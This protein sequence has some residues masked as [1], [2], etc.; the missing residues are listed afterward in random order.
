VE[1]GSGAPP[2]SE[3][4]S[5]D[6]ASGPIACGAGADAGAGLDGDLPAG[7]IDVAADCFM[8]SPHRTGTNGKRE[9]IALPY[10]S[11]I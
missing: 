5:D 4:C 9:S 7:A 10:L 8:L 3:D 2:V 11:G 1:L 6:K